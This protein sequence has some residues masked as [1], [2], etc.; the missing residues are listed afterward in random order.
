MGETTRRRR[1]LAE[2]DADIF[3]AVRNI[4]KSEGY[5]ELTFQ[6]VAKL[7][8][9][10]RDTLY[11]RFKSPFDLVF[12]SHLYWEK[13]EADT[14]TTTAERIN[15][16]NL[17]EDLTQY[18]SIFVNADLSKMGMMGAVIVEQ[19]KHNKH[20]YNYLNQML[21]QI[22]SGVR[23]FFDRAI[24]RGEIKNSPS[25]TAIDMALNYFQLRIVLGY[26]DLTNT[27]RDQV[28]EVLLKLSAQ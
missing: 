24:E 6:K 3:T 21:I 26:E 15:T 12:A 7:S 5:P 19:L 18:F 13:Q 27:D 22:R 14:R 10:S 17:K 11:R 9:T 23:I 25:D 16:G 20:V 4:L 2:L 28:V 8:H 1:D